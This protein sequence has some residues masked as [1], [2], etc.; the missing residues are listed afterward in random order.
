MKVK[1]TKEQIQQ[2]VDDPVAA[3]SAKIKVSDPWWVI[4]LKV[5]AYL[6]GLLLAGSCTSLLASEIIP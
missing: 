6:I 1:L 5:V 2:V 4:A 3:E